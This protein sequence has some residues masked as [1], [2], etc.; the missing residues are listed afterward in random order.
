MFS[1]LNKVKPCSIAVVL[2]IGWV[3]K[4]CTNFF[5]FFFLLPFQ[6][7]DNKDCSTVIVV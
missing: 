6:V 2:A 5:F 1:S 4:C 7:D 3:T